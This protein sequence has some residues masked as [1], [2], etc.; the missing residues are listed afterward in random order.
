MKKWVAT[1]S[2]IVACF[3]FGYLFFLTCLVGFFAGKY[4]SGKVAGER[5]RFR[6]IVICFGRWRVHLH[7]WLCSLG[8]IGVTCST[9]IYLWNPPVTYGLLGGLAFHGIYCYADWYKIVITQQ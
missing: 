6:S 5:G 9:G 7:H 8:L 4:G 1:L 3:V 2:I